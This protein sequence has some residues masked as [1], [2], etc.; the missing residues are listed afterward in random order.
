M[1]LNMVT[2]ADNNK[3][4]LETIGLMNLKETIKSFLNQD[5]QETQK[6][7][8]YK[9]LKEFLT[10]ILM[11]M[12]E[13]LCSN[14]KISE[15][16]LLKRSYYEFD[17][18]VKE[19]VSD[20][21]VYSL[22]SLN[23]QNE[24]SNDYATYSALVD[25]YL[26]IRFKKISLDLFK[27]VLELKDTPETEEFEYI[28]EFVQESESKTT[29]KKLKTVDEL[30]IFKSSISDYLNGK[31]TNN[32]FPLM[33]HKVYSSRQYVV[34]QTHKRENSNK[35]WTK[36]LNNF[37]FCGI[38][39]LENSTENTDAFVKIYQ[40]Y[41]DIQKIVCI[42]GI[43][44]LWYFT[45]QN[46]LNHLLIVLL[47]QNDTNYKSNRTTLVEKYI[48]GNIQNKIL[49]DDDKDGAEFIYLF[50]IYLL[51]KGD[52]EKF[53]ERILNLTYVQTFFETI[54]SLIIKISVDDFYL[55]IYS[56]I[57]KFFKIKIIKPENLND[58]PQFPIIVP[59]LDVEVR[60]L[61]DFKDSFESLYL[62]ISDSIYKIISVYKV[63]HHTIN[64]QTNSFDNEDSLGKDYI[65]LKTQIFKI[66]LTE[67]NTQGT[68]DN[69]ENNSDCKLFD[70][71][72]K[73][74]KILK[75]RFINQWIIRAMLHSDVLTER[76][77][78]YLIYN[79]Y[80]ENYEETDSFVAIQYMLKDLNSQLYFNKRSYILNTDNEQT[81]I[82]KEQNWKNLPFDFNS[83]FFNFLISYIKCEIEN[84]TY[85]SAISK[86]G[87]DLKDSFYYYEQLLII[88]DQ[89]KIFNKI[90]FDVINTNS[91][92]G[93]KGSLDI[94]IS[95][96]FKVLADSASF[97]DTYF[98]EDLKENLLDSNFR[99][100]KDRTADKYIPESNIN[101]RFS[102][103]CPWVASEINSVY[104][105]I[106]FVFFKQN[107]NE[108]NIK[109]YL[110]T[111]LMSN[112]YGVSDFIAL[113]QS[114]LYFNETDI[115]SI[116]GP[117]QEPSKSQSICGLFTIADKLF[118]GRNVKVF[119][120][121]ELDG[122][123]NKINIWNILT[124]GMS[125]YA[126]NKNENVEKVLMNLVVKINTE[127]SEKNI[128]AK[129]DIIKLKSPNFFRLD[130]EGELLS[131][132]NFVEKLIYIPKIKRTSEDDL[133]E[134]NFLKFLTLIG[135]DKDNDEN[136]VFESLILFNTK[137]ANDKSVSETNTCT[138][139]IF[140]F[141]LKYLKL[142]ISLYK[143]YFKN[144]DLKFVFL[145]TKLNA[146]FELYRML[147]TPGFKP[148][149]FKTRIEEIN[150]KLDLFA[151]YYAF[152]KTYRQLG[153][154]TL[155]L[156]PNE[157]TK[158]KTDRNFKVS[159]SGSQGTDELVFIQ[160]F[161]KYFVPK[162]GGTLFDNSDLL[163]I[164]CGIESV[165]INVD[166]IQETY[167]NSVEYRTCTPPFDKTNKDLATLAKKYEAELK[168]YYLR[169]LGR[170]FDKD[171][172]NSK[173]SSKY[174]E[175]LNTKDLIFVPNSII[176]SQFFPK[177]NLE[178]LNLDL[179]GYDQTH[180]EKINNLLG[181]GVLKEYFNNSNFVKFSDIKNQISIKVDKS[182][183]LSIKSIAEKYRLKLIRF[184]DD[185]CT[186]YGDTQLKTNETIDNLNY[187]SQKRL[188]TKLL[189][190]IV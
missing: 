186:Q 3:L 30:T 176:K 179:P 33:L 96:T 158:I 84:L 168:E 188:E 31:D 20:T 88:L 99:C 18:L 85:S 141:I 97:V 92:P 43:N 62:K 5:L 78:F 116:C 81:K 164:E 89:Y 187:C 83:E 95:N 117:I 138:N 154:L 50:I 173:N 82:L 162:N 167:F 71:V 163:F 10:G 143:R 146:N 155:S 183:V 64:S 145:N 75:K 151:L 2:F 13:F 19:I 70:F 175:L 113:V 14:V 94:L 127:T 77:V 34:S 182:L 1:S 42:S 45:D 169:D 189:R 126:I 8:T 190:T 118:D 37:N 51:I 48:F 66:V 100:F 54:Y 108:S 56:R 103:N 102:R 32:Y 106:N 148:E 152:F 40:K 131:L 120:P 57:I 150:T 185:R 161:L 80:K 177:I 134:K 65:E 165:P 122:I 149:T 98:P 156:T 59:K 115:N 136:K 9:N 121:G 109:K 144:L 91:F 128:E 41:S 112:Y 105:Y 170:G 174:L 147:T 12:K 35:Y 39:Q 107:I 129:E 46:F 63:K 67:I 157:V 130:D 171:Y 11:P 15:E 74:E 7:A 47:G 4:F 184:I 114:K 111:K 172:E 124:A 79:F 55:V 53:T 178:F 166:N 86:Y 49:I 159:I 90:Y 38:N 22:K 140:Y 133:V 104:Y 72:I 123:Q 139:F 21:P 137:S 36:L 93:L 69:F 142:N 132:K 119:N 26:K 28:F 58:D 135:F 60:P 6:T 23:K 125:L 160:E 87:D 16:I 25:N 61:S 44:D 24:F 110:D 153:V 181:T 17:Y 27:S 73:E 101:W 180:I 76:C 52:K 29:P 68:K